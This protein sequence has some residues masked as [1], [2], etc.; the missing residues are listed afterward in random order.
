MEY[1]TSGEVFSRGGREG[2]ASGNAD[3]LVGNET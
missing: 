1:C 3:V 2:E